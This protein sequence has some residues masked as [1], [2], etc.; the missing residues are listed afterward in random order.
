MYNWK[1]TILKCNDTLKTAIQVLDRE[2]LRIVMVVDEQ[3]KLVGT[4]TDGDIRRAMIQHQGMDTLLVTVMFKS[5]TT[6]SVNDDHDTILS[7]MKNKG[8]LQVPILDIDKR[9]VGLETLHHLIDECKIEN[10]VFLMAGGFG[11]RLQPLTNDIPKPLLKVGKKPILETIL[12]QFAA[13]GFQNFYIS[14]HYKAEM[15]REHFDNGS[16]WGVN[17]QY[18]HEEEPLGTAGAL[19]LL[20]DELPD[21]P[22][23][24]MNGDLLTKINFERLLQ[25]H[26]E[27]DGIATMCV[28]EYDFQVPYGVIKA[29]EHRITKIVEKPIHKFFVNAGIYVLNS[30][31]VKSVNGKEY[32]DM[33]NLLEE[34]I[35]NNM[36]VNNFPIHEYWLDIGRM[37]EYEHAN[38]EITSSFTN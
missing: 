14:T 34:Q 19:G 6:A 32:L 17:I 10:P 16:K 28:R 31:L 11:K 30:S 25:F 27:H 9:V 18:V 13:A 36:Q 20:P 3:N 2:A 37:E 1:K 8:L 15:I 12:E 23:L 29:K 38:N 24:M 7:M 35:K 4:V 26:N 22:I 5:P 33:P 21:I